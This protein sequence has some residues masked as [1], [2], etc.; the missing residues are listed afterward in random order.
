MAMRLPVGGPRRH[1]PR[2]WSQT[3][4][5]DRGPTAGYL[6]DVVAVPHAT[7]ERAYIEYINELDALMP[8]SVSICYLFPLVVS[9]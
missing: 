8:S 6:W 2:E 7:Q 1:I 3:D 4:Q 9:L 5:E